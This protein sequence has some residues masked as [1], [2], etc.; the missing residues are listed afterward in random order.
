[1]WSPQPHCQC[2]PKSARNL[3]RTYHY[4]I[5]YFF[6]CLFPTSFFYIHIYLHDTWNI[7]YTWLVDHSH[8]VSVSWNLH[9]TWGE[10]LFIN[11][12]FIFFKFLFSNFFGFYIHIY[13]FTWH[14]KHLI[15]LT[16]SPQ[17]RCQRS[18]ESAHNLGEHILFYL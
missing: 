2:S 1:M 17:P 10:I 14:M 13:T 11:L 18:R 7:I 4:K 16:C 8:V 3:G 6:F 5:I 15:Y 12:F 9:I